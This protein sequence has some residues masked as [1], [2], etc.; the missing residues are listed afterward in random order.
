LFSRPLS[1][2]P[3]LSVCPRHAQG[4]AGL[5]LGQATVHRTRRAGLYLLWL[6]R[7]SS[8]NERKPPCRRTNQVSSPAAAPFRRGAS[9]AGVSAFRGSAWRRRRCHRT[10]PP[11]PRRRW[12]TGPQ[13]NGPL[14]VSARL[15]LGGDVCISG[16]RIGGRRRARPFGWDVFVN[17]PGSISEGQTG[18]IECDHYHP[19]KEDVR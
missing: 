14:T 1:V 4:R 10:R 19:F 18:D 2:C 13:V 12:L 17:R 15:R 7:R 5:G 9:P 8:N 3:Q 6:R 16:R 11:L